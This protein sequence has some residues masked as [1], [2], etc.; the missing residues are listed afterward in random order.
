M[1]IHQENREKPYKCEFC[2]KA[3]YNLGALNIHK[4]IHLGQMIPCSLCSKKY[5]RKVDL[6]RHMRVHNATIINK[7]IKK[8]VSIKII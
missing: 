7:D 5:C 1:K 6:E 2:D 3:F 4:R 8:I